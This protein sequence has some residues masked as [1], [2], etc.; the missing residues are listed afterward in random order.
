MK[1]TITKK[2]TGEIV[3]EL[4]E[5]VIFIFNKVLSIQGKEETFDLEKYDLIIQKWGS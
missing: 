3:I 2:E 1:I 4:I 5:P